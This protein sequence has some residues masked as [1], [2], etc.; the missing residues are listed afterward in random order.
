MFVKIYQFYY[1]LIDLLTTI[2][3]FKNIMYIFV[4]L[5]RKLRVLKNDTLIKGNFKV[6]WVTFF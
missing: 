3:I 2:T 4:I 1:I 6:L 5:Y